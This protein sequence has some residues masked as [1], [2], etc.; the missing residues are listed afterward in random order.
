MLATLSSVSRQ[1]QG[2]AIVSY[3]HRITHSWIFQSKT[4][5]ITQD[6][7]KQL[8]AVLVVTQQCLLERIQCGNVLFE[9]ETFIE[10]GD[11]LMKLKDISKYSS[12]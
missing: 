12:W 8:T 10:V 5:H 1:T 9:F 6:L 4:E 7:V 3:L 2:A 11:E